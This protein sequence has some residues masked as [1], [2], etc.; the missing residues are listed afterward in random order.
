MNNAGRRTLISIL[1]LAA[2]IVALVVVLW[3]SKVRHKF[4]PGLVSEQPAIKLPPPV[5]TGRTPVEEALHERRSVRSFSGSPLGLSEISQLLWAAQGITE[6][7][8]GLRTAPS[9]GAL[10]PLEVYVLS[11]N[12]RD[13]PAGIYRYRPPGHELVKT[14]DGDMRRE[15]YSAAADQTPVREAPAVIIFSAHYGRT[16]AKYGKRGIR[17][18]NAEAGSAVENVYLQAVS[19]GLGTVV[20]GAFK[21]GDVKDIVKMAG[22]EEPLYIMPVG[23]KS[24]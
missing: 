7:G 14:A 10:Y 4:P 9:A 16:I 19:L 15:L 17:Y 18:V 6:A 8:K 13:L 21:D 1:I 12:V 22:D 24:R 5:Y 20:I 23:K 2:A 3:P 11:G